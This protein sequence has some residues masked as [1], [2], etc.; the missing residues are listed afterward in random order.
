MSKKKIVIII[1]ALV[2]VLAIVAIFIILKRNSNNVIDNRAN[3]QSTNEI[4]EGTAINEIENVRVDEKGRKVNT[5][6]KINKDK[7][8]VNELEFTNI[9]L[10]YSDG[11]TILTADVKNNS[12]FNYDNGVILEIKLFNSANEVMITFP[13]MTS[14]L[15]AGGTS[16]ISGRVTM[17]CSSAE[18]IEISIMK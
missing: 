9:S 12:E 8:I 15:L 5:S 16:N 13:L 2:L 4:E 17:D 1:L 18:D 10:V 7:I 14:S 11:N 6:P 3:G